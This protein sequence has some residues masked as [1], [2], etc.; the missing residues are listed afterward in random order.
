METFRVGVNLPDSKLGYTPLIQACR[1]Y[2]MSQVMFLLSE[3]SD[4]DV[5]IADNE[6]YTALHFAVSCSKDN[7]YTQLNEACIKGDE[8]EMI[9]LVRVDDPM[10][11]ALDNIGY[12][13]LHYACFLGH[14]EIVKTLMLAGAE[15]T[16][17]INDWLTP[18]QVA[19]RGQPEL[20]KLFD[21]ETLWEEKQTN[22]SNK[23][24]V[25]CL[26]MLTLRLIKSKLIIKNW[27]QIFAV[28]HI[29]LKINHLKQKHHKF[30][31]KKH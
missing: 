8:T 21:K 25:R 18:A 23:L 10:I 3:V 12:T 20:L 27:C 14:G 9:R 24:S 5:N 7:G 22:N 2:S 19:K 15:E 6:G 13:P 16:I 30:N 17:T 11:N 26:V 1:S 31:K 4:L 28:V 29:V